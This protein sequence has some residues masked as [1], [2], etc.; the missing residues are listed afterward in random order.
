MQ[1]AILITEKAPLSAAFAAA[2]DRKPQPDRRR[3][4]STGR[5]G[6][7]RKWRSCESENKSCPS[8]GANGGMHR[9]LRRRRHCPPRKLMPHEHGW[10]PCSCILDQS[11]RKAVDSPSGFWRGI[12]TLPTPRHRA[13]PE[14][15]AA[16]RRLTLLNEA[17]PRFRRP[18]WHVDRNG[19]ETKEARPGR[20]L[21]AS[22]M[23]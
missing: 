9:K 6:T 20:P 14:L 17:P 13:M 18:P 3:R 5:T 21:P 23:R 19:Q 16:E 11:G 4:R 7:Q 2:L 10:P 1:G 15:S 12:R 22:R 8:L